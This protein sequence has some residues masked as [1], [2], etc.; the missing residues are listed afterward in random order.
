MLS[1]AA[2]THGTRFLLPNTGKQNWSPVGV[3]SSYFHVP[4]K[5]TGC[6]E[7]KGRPPECSEGWCHCR[8]PTHSS[9]RREIVK[10]GNNQVDI[11]FVSRQTTGSKLKVRSTYIQDYYTNLW[12][13]ELHF[14]WHQ[15]TENHFVWINVVEFLFWIA[16]S[17][18]T[19]SS[20]SFF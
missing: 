2:G 7:R 12:I 4:S 6:F 11:F 15:S 5:C 17:G 19:I 18:M 20:L 14:I 9:Q 1:F 13:F 8:N 16:F 3:F 10:S